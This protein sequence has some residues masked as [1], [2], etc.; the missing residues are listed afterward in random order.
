MH[1]EMHACV[2]ASP[3]KPNK[4]GTSA[5]LRRQRS[6]SR[7]YG[8]VSYRKWPLFVSAGQLAYDST[9]CLLTSSISFAASLCFRLLR[10]CQRVDF[11]TLSTLLGPASRPTSPV[12]RLPFPTSTT[13]AT[14]SLLYSIILRAINLQS[15]ARCQLVQLSTQTTHL[16]QGTEAQLAQSLTP[17]VC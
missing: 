17:L 11:P 3:V 16:V 6:R 9:Y 7:Y 4:L 1:H 15:G 13:H 14:A 10:C 12:S 5:S 8:D 2:A